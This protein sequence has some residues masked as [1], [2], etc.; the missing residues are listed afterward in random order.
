MA[1]PNNDK[2][3]RV[4]LTVVTSWEACNSYDIRN[5]GGQQIFT[6]SEG[7]Q[8]CDFS[9]DINDLNTI[10]AVLER[11]TYRVRDRVECLCETMLRQQTWFRHARYGQQRP[12]DNPQMLICNL[13]WATNVAL[14]CRRVTVCMCVDG[15]EV[16][17]V[18]R[19]FKCCAC[20]QCLACIGCCAHEVKVLSPPSIPV[21]YIRQT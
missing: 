7:R 10:N 4:L 20:C 12:G 11:N 13:C 5:M 1:C 6:A 16:I 17:S 2:L 19:E 15:Q 21:G 8:S 9:S 3:L 18:K 14:D